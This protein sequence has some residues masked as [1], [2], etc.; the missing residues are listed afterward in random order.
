MSACNYVRYV[1]TTDCGN[2]DTSVLKRQIER[3]HPWPIQKV[4]DPARLDDADFVTNNAFKVSNKKD[5]VSGSHDYDVSTIPGYMGY[6]RRKRSESSSSS[7]S[8]FRAGMKW[9]IRAR[10]GW[11]VGV[12]TYLL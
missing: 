8:D 7:S 5:A 1:K 9:I 3:R 4:Q 6:Q 2:A 12:V 11:R 10:G